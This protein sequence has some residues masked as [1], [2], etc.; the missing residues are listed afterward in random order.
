M[1]TILSSVF[2]EVSK[3][4]ARLF[5]EKDRCLITPIIKD[6]ML[7]LSVGGLVAFTLQEEDYRR[8]SKNGFVTFGWVRDYIRYETGD[9]VVQ[10]TATIYLG[11]NPVFGHDAIIFEFP[12]WCL[13]IGYNGWY[14]ECD[15]LKPI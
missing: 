4:V 15:Y 12:G 7:V 14:F 6:D 1:S 8:I 10:L 2:S 3:M 5:S 11:D 9:G 13:R